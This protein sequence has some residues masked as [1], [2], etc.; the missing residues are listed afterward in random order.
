MCWIR[1]LRTKMISVGK[2]IGPDLIKK[3]LHL[4]LKKNS[5]FMIKTVLWNMIGRF[6][7]TAS[8]VRVSSRVPW[9]SEKLM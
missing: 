3:V 5:F 8:P 1:E 7:W 6:W 9:H 4:W 2:K